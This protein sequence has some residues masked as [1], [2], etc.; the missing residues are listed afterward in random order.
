MKVRWFTWTLCPSREKAPLL[1]SIVRTS[2][3]D[4]EPWNIGDR[5]SRCWYEFSSPFNPSHRVNQHL[6]YR[7][8]ILT[9]LTSIALSADTSPLAILLHLPLLAEDK[10]TPYVYVPSKTALGR[11]CGVSR[12]VIACSITTNEAGDLMGQI[13]ALKDQVERLMI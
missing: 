9:K 10:N 12:A 5:H 1:T 6:C 4:T 13:R 11:A 7:P 3:Q 8:S 2:D